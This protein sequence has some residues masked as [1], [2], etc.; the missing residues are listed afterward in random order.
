VQPY[1]EQA[2]TPV[3][4]SGHELLIG[5]PWEYDVP[6]C[7]H[8]VAGCT[9][10]ADGQWVHTIAG[11]MMGPSISVVHLNSHCHAPT[12]LSTAVYAC[13]KGTPLAD[14]NATVGTLV[15]ET[16][17]VYGGTGAP[18]LSG[19]RFDEPGYIA[20]ADCLW[21]SAAYGLEAPVD[22]EDVPLHVVKR[23]NATTYHY[24]EMS[25][26]RTWGFPKYKV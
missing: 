4:R 16:R 1:N 18:A 22:L 8:G 9:Q 13:A 10:E 25:G 7:G 3:S 23:A 6:Q 11:S 21:G 12:C 19:G 17:P 24:G 26:T 15:C 2:V 5:S 20:L 14:C